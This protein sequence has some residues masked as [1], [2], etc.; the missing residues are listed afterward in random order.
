MLHTPH[1]PTEK[2][3]VRQLPQSVGTL[4]ADDLLAEGVKGLLRVG[5]KICEFHSRSPAVFRSDVAIADRNGKTRNF[6]EK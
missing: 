1:F 2:W 4:V 3:C 6:P 5:V